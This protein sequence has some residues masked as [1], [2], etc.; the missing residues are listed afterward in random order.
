MADTK[1]GKNTCSGKSKAMLVYGILQ[2]GSSII[3]AIALAA[4]AISLC[5]IKYESKNFN[6][7]V[8]EKLSQLDSKAAAVN[9]CNGGK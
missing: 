3:S 7:C 1:N 5:N 8:E 9:Y 6:N 2:L 4:I